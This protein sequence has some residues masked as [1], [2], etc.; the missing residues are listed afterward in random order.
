MVGV[1]A[2]FGVS[3]VCSKADTTISLSPSLI[4]DT[5]PSGGNL[6]K[7]MA[8]LSPYIGCQANFPGNEAAA[9]IYCR[10]ISSCKGKRSS[11]VYTTPPCFAAAHEGSSV[12]A[13]A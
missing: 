8:T 10:R 9:A 13:K 11:R 12:L 4:I 3:V 1:C 5:R 2:S 6:D 7:V